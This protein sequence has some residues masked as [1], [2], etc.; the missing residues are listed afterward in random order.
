MMQR[1]VF[2]AW[3]HVLLRKVIAHTLIQI[4]HDQ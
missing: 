3:F 4:D 2:V 1:P